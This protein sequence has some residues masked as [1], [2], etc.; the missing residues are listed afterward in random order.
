MITDTSI[1]VLE[2][3]FRRRQE[4][5]EAVKAAIEGTEEVVWPV[6]SS[7]L[8][9]IAVFF[10]LIV[11]VPGIPGQIFKDLSWAIIYSQI[12]STL[13]PITFVTMTSV[14]LKVK[15]S[16]YQPI[17]WTGFLERRLS[18]SLPVARR[19]R[20]AA[21]VL[22]ITFAICSTA[23]VIFNNLDREVLPKVDQG[24]LL[25]SV[26]MPIGTR[27]EV[28]DRVC[29]RIEK[30]LEPVQEV[31][32]VN[33]TVGAERSEKGQVKVESLR[34][35]QA[36][37][38][39]TLQD[40][41]KK[42]SAEVVQL[43]RERA[44]KVGLREDQISFVLQENEFAFAEGGT[45]PIV[46]EVKGYDF[47]EMENLTARLHRE[48]DGIEGVIDITDDQGEL[49]DETKLQIN[50][51]RSALY[52]ISALDVSLIAKAAIEGVVATQ[53]REGG[54]EI[55]IRVRLS[56]KDRDNI[57]NLDNL[58]IYSKVMDAL[59]PLK[60]IARVEKSL[61]PTEI[62]RVD[63]QRTI[64]VSAD[65]MKKAKSKDVL[66]Q[67]Q[68]M[69]Q[70]LS[71]SPESGLQA[72]LS[73]KA[74]EVKENFTMVIFAFLLAVILNYMIMA[75]QF[76]SFLQPLI[77]MLTVPLALFGVAVALWLSGNSLNVISLLGA[78]LLV[79]TSVNN[80]I[81][82]IE[83]INQSREEGMDV[84]KAAMEA[85]KVRTRPI[86]ISA[87]T[88]VV[89]LIPLALGLGEGSELRAPMAV[90]MIGGTVSST[91]LTL[92]V[93]PCF[94]ILMTRLAE[95]FSGEAESM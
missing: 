10:P 64:T 36:L 69:L 53:Y 20:F 41:R 75:S 1:V 63:Q 31:K 6:I 58:L 81:I 79:G 11:F 32:N 22:V 51:N 14:Y 61:G 72:K 76:E 55:D 66:V 91:F 60:E 49:S 46:I 2:N 8:T 52:G 9:T 89:G 24:Q 4:G 59:I 70:N 57:E 92:F 19:V 94:Y 33:V 25:I 21:R 87:L 77:I 15:A 84:E 30:L 17:P 54:K 78:V 50:K 80:G 44:Q 27:L 34:P 47:A 18:E 38:T 13:L 16:G 68:K 83:Y 28:T 12:V 73:G 86:I 71:I 7:N 40:K 45:K 48:L 37:I 67:V 62:K 42:S 93:I 5:E 3:I 26:N 85:A 56:Q 82:L 74:R 29:K 23:F 35:S 43:L 65:I 90:A 95:K 88:S 39:V